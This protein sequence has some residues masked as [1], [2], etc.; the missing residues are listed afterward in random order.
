MVSASPA[1]L[2]Y[3]APR[4]PPTAYTSVTSRPVTQRMM[5]K[6]CT[7]QSRKMPPDAAMYAAGGG[8][9][10]SVVE[11]TVWSVPSSP[12]RTAARAA[13]KPASKRRLKPIC[14][15]TSR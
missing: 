5:S 11:R 9:G 8:A 13:T 12:D 7:E 10:S 6:S 1:S 2:M 14:T 3:S 15:G 4:L